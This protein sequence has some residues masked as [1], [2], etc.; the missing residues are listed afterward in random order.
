VRLGSTGIGFSTYLAF[1]L[2]T[3][4]LGSIA[5]SPQA[6]GNKFK[7]FNRKLLDI[8][9]SRRIH[10]FHLRGLK[11]AGLPTSTQREVVRGRAYQ[12]RG[13]CV[14]IG[15]TRN[16]VAFAPFISVCA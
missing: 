14:P 6:F 7:L 8:R 11:E 1:L 16:F 4:I 5:R 2:G 10:N 15:V 12:F 13:L 3:N 9:M